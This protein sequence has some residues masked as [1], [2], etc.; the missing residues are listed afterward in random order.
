[1]KRELV[2]GRLRRDVARAVGVEIQN[3]LESP[4][5][6]DRVEIV[7]VS[8]V[9]EGLLRQGRPGEGSAIVPAAV[10]SR[11]ADG[12]G[13]L[14][15]DGLGLRDRERGRERGEREHKDRSAAARRG[16]DRPGG[17]PSNRTWR[18]HDASQHGPAPA[19]TARL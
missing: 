17:R 3:Q 4:R 13:L 11:R 7:C 16:A 12:H 5:I 1:M 8:V 15:E 6:E 2:P 9:L 10:A 14:P 19:R 18:R